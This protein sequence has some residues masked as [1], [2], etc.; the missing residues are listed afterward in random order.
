MIHKTSLFEDNF[1]IL[2][3]ELSIALELERDTIFRKSRRTDPYIRKSFDTNLR[4]YKLNVGNDEISNKVILTITPIHLAIIAR[5]I[6]IVRIFME[7]LSDEVDNEGSLNV[8]ANVLRKVAVLSFPKNPLQYAKD[9]RSLDGMNVF[10]LAAKYCTPALKV[11]FDT[12]NTKGLMQKREFHDTLE[13]K[14]SQLQQTPL[15]VAAGK[16]HLSICGFIIKNVA[17]KNP[18]CIKGKTPLHCAAENGHLSV[19]HLLIKNSED[20]NPKDIAGMTPL[21][22]AATHGHLQVCKLIM[23]K[24]TNKNPTDNVGFTPLHSAAMCGHFSI[25]KFFIEKLDDNSPEDFMGRTPQHF[26]QQYGHW[27]IVQ[28]FES[29]IGVLGVSIRDNRKFEGFLAPPPF[30]AV[31]FLTFDQLCTLPPPDSTDVFYGVPLAYK[32]E[33]H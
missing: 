24:V 5:Q 13:A 8:I 31:L 18:E 26:A 23:K 6:S 1:Q 15:H 3:N 17:N 21:H 10:H 9:D 33:T 22:W 2:Q 25:C 19:C 30:P 28:L 27:R 20:K 12:L 7:K 11:L 16:G 14:E 32:F 29:V 4:D